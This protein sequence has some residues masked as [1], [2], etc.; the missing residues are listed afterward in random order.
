MNEPI[1]PIKGRITGKG[2]VEAGEKETWRTGVVLIR[3]WIV[4]NA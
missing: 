2:S 3:V 4:V 1:W